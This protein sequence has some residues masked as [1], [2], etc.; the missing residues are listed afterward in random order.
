MQIETLTQVQEGAIAYLHSRSRP[1]DRRCHR[2]AS[3]MVRQFCAARGYSEMEIL[4]CVRD[5]W[6]V[7]ELERNAE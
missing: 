7:Y 4:H 1:N 5:M 6:D 3:R 2:V